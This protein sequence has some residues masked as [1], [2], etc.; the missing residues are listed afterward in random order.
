[1]YTQHPQVHW[2][3]SKKEYVVQRKGRKTKY[4][5]QR[6]NERKNF[7]FNTWLRRALL[8]LPCLSHFP[9]NP[10]PQHT[11]VCCK[12]SIHRTVCIRLG[13]SVNHTDIKQ[14]LSLWLPY[15]SHTKVCY[16]GAD[17]FGVCLRLWPPSMLSRLPPLTQLGYELPFLLC[18]LANKAR[19]L[20][21]L[22][23]SHL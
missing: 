18:V 12:D 22:K 5:R 11:Q 10:R 21:G 1:M 13:I 2:Q 9:L 20:Q 19:F 8:H 14:R 6:Q 7:C 3:T 16:E 23:C 17:H 4:I 15:T